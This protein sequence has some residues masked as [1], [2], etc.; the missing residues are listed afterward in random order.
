MKRHIFI[1]I[2]TL[3]LLPGCSGW[4]N[5]TSS[6]KVSDDKLFSDRTGFHNALSGVYE[7]MTSVMMYGSGMTSGFCDISCAPFSAFELGD[8]MQIQK[9]EYGSNSVRSLSNGI[10]NASYNAISNINEAL[11]NLEQRRNVVN[12][13][14]EYNLIKG[15]LLGLRAYIYLDLV[16]IFGLDDWSG[17]NAEKLSLPYSD[18]YSSDPPKQLTYREIAQRIENDILESVMLLEN[19]P[20]RGKVDADF[21]SLLNSDGYWTNRKYHLNYYASLALAARFYQAKGD[22]EK[23]IEYAVKSTDSLQS[24]SFSWLDSE[25]FANSFSNDKDW[26]FSSEIL[27]SLDDTDLDKEMSGSYYGI[28]DNILFDTNVANSI[29]SGIS[30]ME[31]FRGPSYMLKLSANGY[32][33]YKF[34][35][36]SG[37]SRKVVMPMIKVCELYYI[38]AESY[39]DSGRF[40]EAAKALDTVRSHRG[41]SSK[42]PDTE[43]NREGIRKYLDKEVLS[44]FM[45][46]GR[47]FYYLKRTLRGGRKIGLTDAYDK[48]LEDFMQKGNML[49]YPDTELVYGRVQEK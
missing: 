33:N 11:A 9:H 42:I 31:D 16:R 21:N 28:G 1:F 40:E 12:D 29:F 18:S 10:W 5:V 17:D 39:L 43:Y 44:E 7:A 24:G 3:V 45:G 34:F 25:S 49:K 36:S 27:F 2:L 46:E 37:S 6:S 14:R 41:I 20:V 8:I 13:L 47:Y 32:M 19:D 23:A 48:F 4:L 30:G 38:I 22:L 35:H 26:Q 15:E